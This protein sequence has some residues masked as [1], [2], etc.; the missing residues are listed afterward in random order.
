MVRGA[1]RLYRAGLLVMLAATLMFA[2]GCLVRRLKVVRPGVASTAKLQVA[3]L[4]FLVQQLRNADEQIKTITAT[5]NMEPSTGSVL[6]GH[7]EQFTEVTGYILL[8]K[9]DMIRLIGLYPVVRNR[10]FDM[11]SNGH[12]FKLYIPAKN[13]FII[14]LN[15]ISQPSLKKLENL[16]PQHIFEAL[17]VS[18]PADGE[19]PILENDTDE[20][21]ADYIL[22]TITEQGGQFLLS[23]SITF[24]RVNLRVTR[25]EIFDA[26]GD[27]ISD[28]R[29]DEYQNVHGI[30][31]PKVFVVMRP[32]DEYGVKITVTKVELNTAMDDTKFA[33]SQPPGTELLNL[34]APKS[35]TP[36]PPSNGAPQP[37][38]PGGGSGQ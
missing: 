17:I 31:I 15:Q 14:G 23:R 16:R 12:D 38:K 5:V 32:K 35:G 22:H 29:Y 10:A 8:R 36:T 34:S 4:P 6:Q 25:Q 37:Q 30:P 21:H 19:R 1:S 2:P 27:I 24:D 20:L 13:Q 9:P 18:P 33:L 11:V 3:S 26:S 28:T 7:V